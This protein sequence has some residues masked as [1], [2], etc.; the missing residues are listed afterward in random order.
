MEQDIS[1]TEVPLVDTDQLAAIEAAIGRDALKGLIA[2]LLRDCE[3]GRSRLAELKSGQMHN[4]LAREAHKLGGMLAQFGCTAAAN[5]FRS[6]SRAAEPGEALA[7]VDDG[8]DLLGPTC[9]ALEAAY[10]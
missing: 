1:Q 7:L 3:A 4:Q 8:L 2:G 5:A 6:C 10:S 9:R